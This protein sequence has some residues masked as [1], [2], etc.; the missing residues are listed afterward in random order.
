MAPAIHSP[1]KI[2]AI[3]DWY[4]AAPKWDRFWSNEV[5]PG[6]SERRPVRVLSPDTGDWV[7]YRIQVFKSEWPQRTWWIYSPAPAT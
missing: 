2:A 4:S 5:G 6:D 3:V 1:E 7:N